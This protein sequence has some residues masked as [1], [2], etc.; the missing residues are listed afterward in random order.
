RPDTLIPGSIAEREHLKWRNAKPIA[1]NPYSPDALQRRLSEKTRPSSMI[2]ID[3]LVRKEAP[4]DA[5]I[6]DD[7]PPGGQP[8]DSPTKHEASAPQTVNGSAL[9]EK[10]KIGREYYINDPER[11]RMGGGGTV[12]QTLGLGQHPGQPGPAHSTDDEKVSDQTYYQHSYIMDRFLN[13]ERPSVGRTASLRSNRSLPPPDERPGAVGHR[14]ASVDLGYQ[15]KTPSAAGSDTTGV[16]IPPHIIAQ[17]EQETL[18][19]D[20]KRDSFRARHATTRQFV[21]NPIFDESSAGPTGTGEGSRTT[22]PRGYSRADRKDDRSI[23][24]K[25][26]VRPGPVVETVFTDL[27]TLRRSASVKSRIEQFS[28]FSAIR[29]TESHRSSLSK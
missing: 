11:L 7:D 10:K 25:E 16:D 22:L 20:Y 5:I 18:H 6:C 21:L 23:A 2:E 19:S 15:T 3:R 12:K 24:A 26:I 27:C 29:R 1:N 8:H 14:A 28:N 9:S 13:A 4:S 17:F